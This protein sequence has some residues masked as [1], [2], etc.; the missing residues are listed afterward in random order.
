M[1]DMNV[2]DTE[3]NTNVHRTI[4]KWNGQGDLSL[5]ENDSIEPFEQKPN[6]K[7]LTVGTAV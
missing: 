5:D 3:M 1:F 7:Y 6:M 2:Q 4:S